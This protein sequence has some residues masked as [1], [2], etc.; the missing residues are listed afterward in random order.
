MSNR[1]QL[2]DPIGTM[3]KLI[4]LNFMEDNTKI[5]IK[6]HILMLQ[7]PS[8]YQFIIRSF[9]G[10]GRENT[11]ELYYSIIRLIEWYL[12]PRNK[13]TEMINNIESNVNN[14]TE[15]SESEE[16][17][18]NPFLNNNDDSN[19]ENNNILTVETLSIEQQS[20]AWLISQS[21]EIRILV[22]FLIRS[23]RKLQETYKH[24]NVVL[25]L[26]FYINI[27]EDGLSGKFKKDKLPKYL[28]F[29]QNTS[30]NFLDYNK[31]KNLWTL[32]SLKRICDLY[33]RCFDS[34]DMSPDAPQST[35]NSLL[36]PPIGDPAHTLIIAGYVGSIDRI[37][38][39]TDVEFQKLIKNSCEG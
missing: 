30:D 31:I 20:N 1:K 7:P 27:L 12:L 13:N 36:I 4:G 37:L 11:S 17:N 8:S 32:P 3:C 26:Q 10:D 6:E 2:L 16:W 22:K 19:S 14:F 39:E 15:N 35:K 24:G 28:L 38:T 34:Y 5:S 18:V 25:C 21:D 9:N 33:Q 29:Q 23:L